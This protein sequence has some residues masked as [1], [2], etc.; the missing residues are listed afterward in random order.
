ME[1]LLRGI[2]EFR[3]TRRPDY[4][5]TFAR[6]AL[7]QKP[8][9]LL[10][11]CSDSRVVPNLFASAEPG[12]LMVVRNVGNLVPPVDPELGRT[13]GASVP[14]AIEF[15]IQSLGVRDVIVCGHS[16]CGAMRA[17]QAG[18][19][20]PGA[21]NLAAWLRHGRPREGERSSVGAGL[22]PW[23]ALS[24]RNV[25]LQLDHLRTYAAVQ[26]A[27][28]AGRL[29]LSG[30]WFDIGR[31]EVLD[32]DAAAGRFVVLDEARVERLLAQRRSAPR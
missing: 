10:I 18:S 22:E 15:A 27:E 9:A 20:V 2:A 14:A 4:A 30:W 24:Q 13:P 11:A 28:A 1:K 7:G 29:R 25:L 8:D 3:R 31:A 21:P 5:Q 17:I 16:D 12:D 23:N 26:H 6:L 19:T 32:H